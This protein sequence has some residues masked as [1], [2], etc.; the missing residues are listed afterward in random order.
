MH[1]QMSTY[2]SSSQANF[3]CGE[4]STLQQSI[5][6]FNISLSHLL[7]TDD[8]IGRGPKMQIAEWTLRVS[9]PY[10]AQIPK[11]IAQYETAGSYNLTWWFPWNYSIDCRF[12]TFNLCW[13]WI[14]RWGFVLKPQ[15]LRTR[16]KS[17]PT[18]IIIM[19]ITT[20]TTTTTIQFFIY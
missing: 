16:W 7:P 2:F 13:Q 18:I 15:G 4:E 3:V 14:P 6:F 20:T 17:N 5:I 9:M 11:A 10:N 8:F 19:I 1:T 12:C